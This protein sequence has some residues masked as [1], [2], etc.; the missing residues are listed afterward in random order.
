MADFYGDYNTTETVPIPFNTFD[1]N[2]P[3]AS[4][5]ITDLVAA[6]IHIH[7][8]GAVAQRT[9]SAGVTVTIDFDSV[10]GNHLILIDLSDNTHAG[11][12]AVG[13]RYQVRI[14]GTT[15]DGGTINGWVGSFSIGCSLRPT[16]SGRT[17]DIQTT[18]EVDANLTMINAVAQ[19][20]TDLA[21]ISQYLFANS[22]TLTDILADDSVMA[23][24][25]ATDGDISQYDE[26]S[27]SQ[28]S[29][30]DAINDNGANINSI[31]A[32]LPT[33]YIQGSPDVGD[34]LVIIPSL[35]I[36]FNVDLA[37]TVTI[38]LGIALNTNR[39]SIP[40]QAEITPGTIT[41]QRKIKGGTSWTTVVSNAAMS[42]LDGQTIYFEAFDSGSGYAEGDSILVLIKDV[43]VVIN[44]ITYA[45]VGSLGVYG[46]FDI[47]ESTVNSNLTQIGGD[48]QSLADLK[49]FVDT[50]YDPITHDIETVKVCTSNS[51]MR[52][53]NSAALAATALSDAVWTGAA[54]Q[55]L[56]DWINGGRL[57]LILDIIAGDV[58][59]LNGETMRGTDGANTIAPNTVV[60]DPSGTGAALAV[61]INALNDFDPAND[62]VVD[63]TN[64]AIN[65]DMRGTNSAALAVSTALETTLTAMKGAGWTTET[66][67]V[68]YDAI[69]VG[70]GDATEAKQDLTL[71]D[72]VEMKG[73]GW[74]DENLKDI[75]D[76]VD[77]ITGDAS[78]ANQTTIINH[79]IA[80]KGSGWVDENLKVIQDTINSVVGLT[81][82]NTI[83]I[84]VQDGDALNIVECAVEIWDSAGTTF[85]ERKS[86]NSSGQITV[87]ADDGTYIVKL[88]KAGY[89]FT[90]QALVVTTDASVT[91]I[92][93]AFVPPVSSSPSTCTIWDKF[94]A[95]GV[96]GFASTVTG[97]AKIIS[98]PYDYGG[99]LHPGTIVTGVYNSVTGVLT[100]N[101]VRG[102][103][104]QF[105]ATTPD[106]GV[107]KI[108]VVPDSSGARLTDISD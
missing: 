23:K 92:G 88:H 106:Y 22:S 54:A 82:S 97:T 36:P 46:R 9:S 107:D 17:L 32:K 10:T 53:T 34:K 96:T 45:V 76:A 25:M 5:T 85:Y 51:D 56:L 68:I 11:F 7:K 49:D 2:D 62:T 37:G 4:V 57:D 38:P 21:E 13:S 77:A 89:T 72:L 100:W 8:D 48:V 61:L 43:A 3:S 60:P 66:L 65:A 39:G 44:A 101:I 90:N 95:T 64:V 14:E 40:L 28:Q 103:K 15:V 63:V 12:Y 33:N 16:V 94:Y 55:A 93:I 35:I 71:T 80:M 105:I 81:G 102:A 84:T 87:N 24:L 86:T 29:I 18:G 78:A 74:V 41:I 1:S 47:R 27:D 26:A 30:R 91:Y 70:G 79:L 75:Q 104:V 19:R 50:G 6:D 73:I 31:V 98:L 108:C 42:N 20:A 59:G 58:V 67:K 83:V 69:P 99:G 52:G